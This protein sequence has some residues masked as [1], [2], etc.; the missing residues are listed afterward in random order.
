MSLAQVLVAARLAGGAS[1]WTVTMQLHETL[2][3]LVGASGFDVLLVRSLTLAKQSHPVLAGVGVG[4]GGALTG[5]S[6]DLTRDR[7]A[8][9]QAAVAVVAYFIELLVVLI[10]EDLTMRLLH[11]L[12]HASIGTAASAKEEE[13]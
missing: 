3:K 5:Q 6:D 11:D 12:E 4:P 9:A 13:Q 8:S 2:A 7:H 10:G 1:V